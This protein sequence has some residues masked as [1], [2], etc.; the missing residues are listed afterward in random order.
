MLHELG[1]APTVEDGRKTTG[2]AQRVGKSG[3]VGLAR[4]R[5]RRGELF[6]HRVPFHCERIEA[7]FELGDALGEGGEVGLLRCSVRGNP[8]WFS[9][10]PFRGGVPRHFFHVSPKGLTRLATCPFCGGGRRGVR[11]RTSRQRLLAGS[12]RR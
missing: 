8:G 7:L 2:G 9:P 1:D 5:F 10:N 12:G 3:D 4:R 11:C 6:L